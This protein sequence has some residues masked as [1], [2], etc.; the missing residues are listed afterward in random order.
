M[1]A[2]LR[3]I[4]GMQPSRPEPPTAE[5]TTGPRLIRLG[6]VFGVGIFVA[7]SWL[8]IAALITLSYGDFLR[9]IIPGTSTSSGYLLALMFAV[10]VGVSVVLH[11][12]GHTVVS[13][14]L[15]LKVSRIVVFLLGGVSELDGEARR[16]RDEFAIAAAGPAVSFLLAGGCW[17]ASTPFTDGSATNVMLFLAAWSNLIIAVFNVLPG[18]PLDGGRLLQAAVWTISRSRRTGVR[19]AA[20]SG[21][22]LAILLA[23]AVLLT[24]A[25][26]RRSGVDA[27]TLA[28]IGIGVA[29]F[30]WFG[31]GQT[32]RAADL[33]DRTNELR[34]RSLIRPSIYLPGGMPLSEALRAA[35]TARAGGIVVVDGDGR[36]R[37]IVD[38]SQV[39]QIGHTQRPWTQL[40]DVARPLR[41]NL[42]L[43]DDLTGEALLAAVRSAPASE[44]LVIGPDGVSRG[45]LA[46]SDLARALGLRYRHA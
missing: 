19:I 4:L 2:P 29:A 44:Y 35:A 3:S 45:V 36:S 13:L 12:I 41:N 5:P 22:G 34:L 10:I 9:Q 18:L 14:L 43:P 17:L 30:L 20:Y 33:T 38:E 1:S 28:V 16:P 26:L 15:G 40:A 23:L 39:S 25:A 21:R 46:T 27:V 6:S 7:P 31:A 42:I 37:A 8:I 24:N 11:E 32:L